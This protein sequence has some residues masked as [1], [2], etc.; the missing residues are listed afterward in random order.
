MRFEDYLLIKKEELKQFEENWV[1]ENKKD[2]KCFPMEMEEGEWE[3][4]Q[5]LSEGY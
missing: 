5:R 4:Q 1:K 3:E 2:P